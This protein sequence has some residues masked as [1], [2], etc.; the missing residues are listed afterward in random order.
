MEQYLVKYTVING[1]Y[2]RVLINRGPVTEETIIRWKDCLSG[3]H[4]T[5]SKLITIIG[6]EKLMYN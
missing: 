6:F 1:E 2:S 4:N 3:I 5:H